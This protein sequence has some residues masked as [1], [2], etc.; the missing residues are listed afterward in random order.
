MLELKQMTT[1]GNFCLL[2]ECQHWQIP[3]ERYGTKDEINMELMKFG[4][5]FTIY[6]RS[7]E[8]EDVELLEM[9]GEHNSYR[10]IKNPPLCYYFRKSKDHKS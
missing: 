10:K 8:I 2:H 3:M 5:V 6:D 4:S 9:Q 1:F 7:H